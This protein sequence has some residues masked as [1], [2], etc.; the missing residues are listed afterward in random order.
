VNWRN[1]LS[2]YARIL[3]GEEEAGYLT[4]KSI[5]TKFSKSDNIQTLWKIHDK[6][7][8]EP[9]IVDSPEKSLL[10]LKIDRGQNIQEM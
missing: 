10:D 2:R 9:R 4:A 8:K 7:L 3:D 6:S 5:E 1:I